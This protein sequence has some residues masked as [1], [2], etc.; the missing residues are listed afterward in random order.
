MTP[1]PSLEGFDVK[2]A[3][4]RMLG[5]PELWWQALALFQ[6]HFGDWADTWPAVGGETGLE[7]RKV[8]ALRSA[9]AN[10]GAV[11]LAFDA[12]VFERFLLERP[13]ETNSPLAHGLRRQLQYQFDQA[14]AEVA[15]A[16]AAHKGVAV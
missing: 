8:H 6:T 5:R 11:R 14:R 7:R 10:I 13:A 1:L 4:D 9:S 15:R 2:S 12:E 16:L 3:V